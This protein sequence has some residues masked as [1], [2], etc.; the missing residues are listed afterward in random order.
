MKSSSLSGICKVC[1]HANAAHESEQCGAR[2]CRKKIKICGS[3]LHYMPSA[4]VSNYPGWVVCRPCPDHGRQ[5]M[6]SDYSCY[7]VVDKDDDGNLII[8]QEGL[9]SVDSHGQDQSIPEHTT[10]SSWQQSET[11]IENATGSLTVHYGDQPQASSSSQAENQPPAV[12]VELYW[13][14][15]LVC[16]EYSGKEVKTVPGRWTTYDA[17][18]YTYYLFKSNDYGLTFYSFTWPAKEEESRGKG[19]KK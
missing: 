16:F 2:D 18:G 9:D 7:P 17:G 15:A 14:K 19:K 11:G 12:E 10:T 13:R 3:T 6:Y 1:D 5:G 8:V 4:E